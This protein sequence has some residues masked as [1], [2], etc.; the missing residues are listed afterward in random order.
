MKQY[1]AD[2]T[3][4]NQQ[5]ALFA[6]EGFTEDHEGISIYKLTDSTGYILVSDQGLTAFRFLAV[7]VQSQTHLNILI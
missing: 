5:L 1:Y 6:T 2:P 3:K 7:R 4:G